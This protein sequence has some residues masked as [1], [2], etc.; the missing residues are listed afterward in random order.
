MDVSI[1]EHE[2]CMIIPCGLPHR[3]GQLVVVIDT[4]AEND[5][6]TMEFVESH[7]LQEEKS[8]N[9]RTADCTDNNFAFFS[10]P[11]CIRGSSSIPTCTYCNKGGHLEATCRTEYP[12]QKP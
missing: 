5:T 1:I 2:L 9:R 11:A 10:T 12:H 4:I 6:L 3:F 7:I 8:M